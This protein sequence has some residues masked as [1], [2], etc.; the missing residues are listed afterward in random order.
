MSNLPNAET[1]QLTSRIAQLVEA[2]GWNQEDLARASGLNR[3]TVRKVLQAT[4][5]SQL[6]I[7]TLSRCA[8]ALGLSLND[9]RQ[10][11]LPSLVQRISGQDMDRNGHWRTAYEA[12]TQPELVAWLDTH[13]DRARQLTADGLDEL[14]SLQGT[15][16]PL[17][18]AGVEH[19]VQIIERRNRVIEQVQAI[20][21]TDQLALLEKLVGALYENIQAYPNRA[22]GGSRNDSHARLR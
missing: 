15:G 6:R 14:L 8:K 11:P 5:S 17:T 7:S 19:F 16:G 20:A 1:L 12:A 21:N 4:E 10:V 9:L 18:Q 13:P 22:S 3:Q 2:R